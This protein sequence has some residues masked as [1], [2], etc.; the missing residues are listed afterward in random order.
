MSEPVTYCCARYAHA[1][2][3]HAQAH[4]RKTLD[5]RAGKV[6]EVD[7]RYTAI[8]SLR[9]VPMRAFMSNAPSA[10]ALPITSVSENSLLKAMGISAVERNHIEGL[11]SS[12]GGVAILTEEQQTARAIVHLAKYPPPEVAD[13]QQRTATRLLR[14]LCAAGTRTVA[15]ALSHLL[16]PTTSISE[17]VSLCDTARLG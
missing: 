13:L 1:H 6:K 5:K 4:A 12:Q 10:W 17:F 9:S 8:L 16:N 11:Q 14:P 15:V 3:T 2:V 7:S